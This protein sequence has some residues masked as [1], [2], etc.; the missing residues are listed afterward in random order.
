MAEGKLRVMRRMVLDQASLFFLS[1]SKDQV[2][3]FIARG[4]LD[5][6]AAGAEPPPMP[7]D[8]DALKALV[9]SGRLG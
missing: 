3:D 4:E 1:M 8:P 6:T 5:G 2:T 7:Y 9:A